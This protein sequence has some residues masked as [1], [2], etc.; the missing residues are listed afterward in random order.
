MPPKDAPT[1]NSLGQAFK[2][3]QG[4]K[5]IRG[6]PDK[7]TVEKK[8]DQAIYDNLRD[9]TD[10]ELHHNVVDGVTMYQEMVRDKASWLETGW[11]KMGHNYYTTLRAKFMS[12]WRPD[13]LL[14]FS[15]PATPSTGLLAAIEKYLEDPPVYGPLLTWCRTMTVHHRDD[16][17]ALLKVLCK[18]KPSV[19]K[20]HRELALEI[21]EGLERT[22]ALRSMQDELHI[23]RNKIDEC[24]CQVTP[25]KPKGPKI[26]T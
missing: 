2:A 11:P 25:T 5:A 12:K 18:C 20:L 10:E 13:N 7:E 16:A 21:L 17:V 22:E 14:S 24:L 15:D 23:M 8:V 4:D 6:R 19:S 26:P 3:K 9:V 1:E